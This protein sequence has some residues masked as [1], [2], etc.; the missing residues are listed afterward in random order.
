MVIALECLHIIETQVMMHG[1][2]KN[3]LSENNL[4]TEQISLI[5]STSQT[6]PTI[7][8][9]LIIAQLALESSVLKVAICL[10]P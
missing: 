10:V 9:A 6:V 2:N 1:S 5:L 8:S 7:I 4:K 3:L